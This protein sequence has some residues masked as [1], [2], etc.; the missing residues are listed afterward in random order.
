MKP[1]RPRNDERTALPPEGGYVFGFLKVKSM[2]VGVGEEHA[3][4]V[5]HRSDLI[6]MNGHSSQTGAD[7]ARALV[8]RW[9]FKFLSWRCS[10]VVYLK[11]GPKVGSCSRANGK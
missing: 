8:E 6:A 10:V 5:A 7:R 4:L 9:R 11:A 2:E 1:R 3:H